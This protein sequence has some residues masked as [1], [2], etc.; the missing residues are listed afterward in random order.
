MVKLE[1]PLKMLNFT[2]ETIEY[3]SA[4]YERVIKATGATEDDIADLSDDKMLLRCAV[5]YLRAESIKYRGAESVAMQL[6]PTERCW[7]Q[8]K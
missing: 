7:H 8:P 5:D 1:L 3:R 2:I 6:P 4:A